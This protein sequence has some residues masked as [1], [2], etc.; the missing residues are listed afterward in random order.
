ML[1]PGA[2]IGLADGFGTT[3]LM[4]ASQ[5]IQSE[6]VLLWLESG[7]Y[8]NLAA[9]RAVA[10]F[11]VAPQSGCVEVVRLLLKGSAHLDLADN[12]GNTALRATAPS[13]HTGTVHLVYLA[14]S[15][16]KTASALAFPLN[17][18]DTWE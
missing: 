2:H 9:S 5:I 7:A 12:I 15:N 18:R 6:T 8:I 4:A 13:V 11:L 17:L 1:E 10:P 14:Q 3:A 16:G